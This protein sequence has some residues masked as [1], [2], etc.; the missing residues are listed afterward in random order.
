MG[1]KTILLYQ[2]LMEKG[3]NS[4]PRRI[5]LAL[6]SIAAPLLKK[7]YEVKIF[8]ALIDPHAPEKLM[9][10]LDKA[11]C[12]GF[13]VWT[14]FPILDS[15]KLSKK[16]KET[17]PNIPVIWGGWHPS[18]LPLN[19]IKNDNIDIVVSGQGEL[20]FLELVQSIE[21]KKPLQGI[22]GI[23]YKID[24]KIYTNPDRKRY[25]LEILPPIPFHIIDIEKY[26]TSSSGKRTL[27]YIS[28][29]GCPA[30]CNFCY[31]SL[32][33]GQKIISVSS[34]KV[35]NDLK[36]IIETYNVDSFIFED[37]NFTF[38]EKRVKEI[39]QGIIKNRW[40][41]K[42]TACAGVSNTLKFNEKTIRLM[43][44]SGCEFLAVGAESGSQ[45]ILDFLN[46]GIKVD[47]IINF[48]RLCKKYDI[49]I[50]FFFMFGFPGETNKD[51]KDT[52]RLIKKVYPLHKGN[53]L[54]FS[55]FTP[56]PKMLLYH[57]LINKYGFKPPESLEGWSKHDI[58]TSKTIWADRRYKEKVNQ[59]MFY[60][61]LAFLNKEFESNIKKIWTKLGYR[62]IYNLM[63][64]IALLRMN[65]DFLRIPLEKVLYSKCIRYVKE[66]P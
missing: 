15:L 33:Y 21:N 57:E 24:K 41:I 43:K 51:L 2:P 34:Q 16:I 42:W 55:F 58:Q 39:C 62:F 10:S 63:H 44:E 25:P 27:S 50:R 66:S 46:K 45:K 31:T 28:S 61:K 6:L 64:K 36:N 17:N 65:Y 22:K 3:M 59:F 35:L 38:D 53:M 54:A 20:T 60:L 9:K 49:P 8:D 1:K 52:F 32:V 47:D 14:G 11:L 19:T 56:F 7:G 18:I 13:S 37:S 12:V 4:K 23:T 29:Q 40:D 48:S 5:P 26:L 30:N